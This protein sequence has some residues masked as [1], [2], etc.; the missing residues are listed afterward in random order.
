MKPSIGID[1]VD[2]HTEEPALHPRYYERV[3]TKFERSQAKSVQD[4]WRYWAAKEAAFK[5]LSAISPGLIFSP[6]SFEFDVK[7]SLVRSNGIEVAIRINAN[8]N[9]VVAVAANSPEILNSSRLQFWV[10]ELADQDPSVAV[11]ELACRKLAPLLGVGSESISFEGGKGGALRLVVEGV[12][13]EHLVSFS[14]HGR[15]V[16]CL[17]CL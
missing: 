13:V 12:G 10:G 15:F 1:I 5:T 4:L 17:V 16:A 3:L 9:Y 14:H 11:R 6:S 8:S 7:Q 2:L